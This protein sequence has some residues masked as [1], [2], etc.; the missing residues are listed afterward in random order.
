MSERDATVGTQ[1]CWSLQQQRR[2]HSSPR[3]H[4]RSGGACKPQPEHTLPLLHQPPDVHIRA[5]LHMSAPH[6]HACTCTHVL[7]RRAFAFQGIMTHW[8]HR[9]HLRSDGVYAHFTCTASAT[10]TCAEALP[11]GNFVLNTLHTNTSLGYWFNACM[12]HINVILAFEYL[13]L[14]RYHKSESRRDSV[15]CSWTWTDSSNHLHTIPFP[16]ST[17][18]HCPKSNHIPTLKRSKTLDGSHFGMQVAI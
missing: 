5:N 2:R 15:T 7:L 18:S 6:T 1:Q 13:H 12:L 17:L 14:P 3:V 9:V 11:F 16:R 8:A 10:C 4:L